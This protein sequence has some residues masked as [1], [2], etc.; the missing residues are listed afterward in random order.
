MSSATIITATPTR[1]NAAVRYSLAQDA[2]MILM[3]DGSA[4]VLDM[5]GRFYTLAPA[6]ALMLQETLT[7]GAAWAAG[8]V[9]EV[10]GEQLSRVQADLDRLL[11][12]MTSRGI[13]RQGDASARRP[14]LLSATRWASWVLTV[15]FGL[16][17]WLKKRPTALLGLA[18]ISFGLFGWTAT[19]SAWRR[20]FPLRAPSPCDNP[21]DA[22]A[23]ARAIDEAVRNA[24]ARQLLGVACK[25][26]ALCCWALARAAGLPATLV[27]GV[28]LFPLAG[29][30]WCEIGPWTVSDD[31][32][33]CKRY[34][35]VLR[36]A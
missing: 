21:L 3:D 8:H 14:R 34:T 17:P 30:C 20:H 5:A 24:A 11:A 36:Y 1:R 25:E 7:H 19:L 15:V 28:E 26:R 29:H 27:I 10:H 31:R 35:P 18:K 13:L 22:A 23:A 32:D 16:M 6:G 2:A 33:S 4:R 12:D 9:A